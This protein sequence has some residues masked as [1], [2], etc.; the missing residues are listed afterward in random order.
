MD[1]KKSFVENELKNVLMKADSSIGNVGYI[2][3]DILGIEVVVVCYKNNT[4]KFINIAG[5]SEIGII[6]DVS[7]RLL[8]D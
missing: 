7:K 5:D 1:D 2:N 3:S 4:M 8:I 6:Y